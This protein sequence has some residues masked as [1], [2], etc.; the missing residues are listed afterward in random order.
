MIKGLASYTVPFRF[1]SSISCEKKKMIWLMYCVQQKREEK[2]SIK[3]SKTFKH[4]TVVLSLHELA[5]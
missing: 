5:M 2:T 4:S 3:K 1:Q